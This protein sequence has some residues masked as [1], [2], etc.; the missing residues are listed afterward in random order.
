MQRDGIPVVAVRAKTSG[1]TFLQ[2]LRGAA[3]SLFAPRSFRKHVSHPEFSHLPSLR[4]NDTSS[5]IPHQPPHGFP[6]TMEDYEL[7]NARQW[8]ESLEG[9]PVAEEPSQ[10]QWQVVG[11]AKKTA[12]KAAP[13]AS[14]QSYA[15]PTRPFRPLPFQQQLG[16]PRFPLRRSP[17][18]PPPLGHFT[19]QPNLKLVDVADNDA[20]YAW[21]ERKPPTDTVRIPAVL[22]MND[23]G[24]QG[25][26]PGTIERLAKENGV[27]V[28]C[29]ERKSLYGS[30][31][32]GVW[33]DVKNVEAAK[34]D[35]FQWIEANGPNAGSHQSRWGK[36]VSLTPE[37]QKRAE[38]AW[39]RGSI[40]L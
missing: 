16:R 31:V 37:L 7:T 40:R 28:H 1:R 6:S 25:D 3:P 8:D 30:L 34:L 20:E 12:A 2:I 24:T 23:R 9:L 10:S 18:K 22:I 36:L 32:F 15:Q 5:A 39:K 4:A 29:E 14:V 19:R 11:A 27:F 35:I 13:R 33:G 26:G 17:Q 38:K 21:R